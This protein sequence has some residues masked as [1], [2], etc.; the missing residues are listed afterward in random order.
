MGRTTLAYAWTSPQRRGILPTP[1]Q[2]NRRLG[3]SVFTSP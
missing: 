2:A 1:Q 3:E